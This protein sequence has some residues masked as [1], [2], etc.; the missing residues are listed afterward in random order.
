M[1]EI[2]WEDEY[3]PHHLLLAIPHRYHH[4]RHQHLLHF[5]QSVTQWDAQIECNNVA[6][7]FRSL[8]QQTIIIILWLCENWGHPSD[9]T[10]RLEGGAIKTHPQIKILR[11]LRSISHS[12]GFA[13][14]YTVCS[15]NDDFLRTR[16]SLLS[17]HQPPVQSSSPVGWSTHSTTSVDD[18]VVASRSVIELANHPHKMNIYELPLNLYHDAT[19]MT[20]CFGLETP[21]IYPLAKAGQ[22]AKLHA[23]PVHSTNHPEASNSYFRS[24]L[25]CWPGQCMWQ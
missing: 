15:T 2:C 22:Q 24:L 12:V 17:T 5:L 23:T 21:S 13:D 4:R 14:F 16:L 6:I 11:L 25:A 1:V 9:A 7:Y 3:L 8:L 20:V 10:Q 19:G 18:V